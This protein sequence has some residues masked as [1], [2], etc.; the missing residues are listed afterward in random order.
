MKRAL[1]FSVLLLVAFGLAGLS[2]G[3]YR[4]HT[5][6]K[7][8]MIKGF[9]TAMAPP[10]TSVG[11]TTARQ[12]RWMPG[13]YAIGS[14]RAHQGID[15]ASQLGGVV[16]AIHIGSGQDVA[17]GADLFDLDTSVEHADL[18]SAV[19]TL[20]NADIA[21]QRQKMLMSGGNT[22]K[23]SLDSAQSSRD[24]ASAAVERIQAT[25]TQKTLVAPFAG[26]LGIRKVDVGQYA[27]AGT[28]LITLQELDPIYVD[29]P[30]PEQSLNLLKEGE[31]V[32]VKVDSRPGQIFHGTI[33]IVD[34]RIQAESRSV[35]VRATFP[36]ADRQLLPGMY[37]N[38]Q[39]IA[40]APRDV[41]IVPRTAVSFSLYGD[42]V[43]VLT[44]KADPPPAGGSAQAAPA[45]PKVFIATRRFVR[46]GDTKDD[47]VAVVEGLKA[48]E[49]VVSEGQIKLQ[50][51]ASVVVDP[52]AKLVPL[53]D[54]PR[55]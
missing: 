18:K 7:P 27:A 42:S 22:A 21:L 37:A 41:V 39:V 11:A 12:A 33:Q 25:I 49:I 26:R 30:I 4:F 35:M 5:V 38:V 2:V 10:S 23:A 8:V 29:F 31:P 9:I 16:T 34:A 17:K 40:G 14:A 19:A 51:G 28:S 1:R 20:T 50:N 32:E 48:G 52:A 36:N 53:A 3:L 24:Q 13:L 45:G 55:E 54:R 15:V 47:Q 6:T 43:F 46:T 44:P